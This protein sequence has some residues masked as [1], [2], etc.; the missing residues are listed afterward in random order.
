LLQVRHATYIA[1]E[2]SQHDVVAILV[3]ALKD[4]NE[5]VR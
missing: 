3:E 1:D 4:K 2:L 5:K